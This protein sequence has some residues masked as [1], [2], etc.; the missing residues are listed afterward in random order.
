MIY[1]KKGRR[2]AL[3]SS[4]KKWIQHP[5]GWEQEHS[6]GVTSRDC[7][8][9][10]G[11]LLPTWL[12]SCCGKHWPITEST[13]EAKGAFSQPAL[14]VHLSML[15]PC[16]PQL[17][18]AGR[19]GGQRGRWGRSTGGI[20]WS[21][22]EQGSVPGWWDCTSRPA[23]HLLCGASSSYYLPSPSGVPQETWFSVL[24]KGDWFIASQLLVWSLAWQALCEM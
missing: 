23:P 20:T 21:A 2:G 22:L 15:Q 11:H 10:Q 5:Q 3:H 12:Q 17:S 7:L 14:R 16:G 24:A 8:L 13:S 18:K 19:V 4:W 9:E 1:A 6:P